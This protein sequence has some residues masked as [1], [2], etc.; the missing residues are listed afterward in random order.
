MENLVNEKIG[1]IVAKNFHAAAVFSKYGLDFCCGGGKSVQEAATKKSVDV[2]K[3][4]EELKAVLSEP[5]ET[6]IDYA[7]WPADLLASYIEKTH[8]R[9][10]REKAPVI[11]AYLNKLCQV[12]GGRHPELLEVNKLFQECAK[13]LGQHLVKEEKIL[14]PYIVQMIN[15]EID[16]TQ[17]AAAPFGSI[18]NP[19][20]MMEHEHDAEGE[21]FEK[22][23]KLTDNYA[24]PADGCSTYRV[25]YEMLKEFEDDLH[26]HIHLENNILFPKSIALQQALN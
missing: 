23:A 13:E 20:H 6:H 26:K 8:H 25:T 2:E 9:Y 4:T 1:D 7:S 3:L 14:F 24:V 18:E 19:I 12:H 5:N 17:L 11:L 21:R 15:S 16:H 22:I 10:V